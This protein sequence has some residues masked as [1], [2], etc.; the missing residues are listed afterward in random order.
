[1]QLTGRTDM[2][3]EFVKGKNGIRCESYELYGEKITEIIVSEKETALF[4]R[5][6]GRYFTVD[7]T[8]VPY[9][10]GQIHALCTVLNKLL[11]EG[12]C[13]VTGLG[14]PSVASD[15]L[16]WRAEP[17]RLCRSIQVTDTGITP[18]STA[19]NSNRLDR[20]AAGIPVIAVGVPTTMEYESN[21]D[22][23]FVTRY[24]IDAE[25]SRYAHI[26]S[27]ALNRSLCP[28]LSYSDISMLMNYS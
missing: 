19:G 24:D 7:S 18:G 22:R 3:A 17:E 27:C 1:M 5:P 10:D 21:N 25:I 13:L 23:F 6:C 28:S 4:N 26:I 2:A 11:P 9:A 8:D 14:N 15:S 16:G 12:K 20:A